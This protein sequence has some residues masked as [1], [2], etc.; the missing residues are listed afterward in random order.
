MNRIYTLLQ[1]LIQ[2]YKIN[3]MT[4]GLFQFN[5]SIINEIINFTTSLDDLFFLSGPKGSSKS[6]TIEKV[7]PE[8][9]KRNLIFRHFCFENSVI[10]DFLLNFY[11][12]LKE[13]S[14]S[15]KV[16]LKKFTTSDFKEKV[17]HYFKSIDANCIVIIENFEKIEK[18]S[19]IADFLSHLAKYMNVKLIIVSR[20]TNNIFHDIK[21]RTYKLE[22]ISEEDFKSK[23]TVLTQPLS[24]EIK[25][26]FYNIT[27]GLELYLNMSIKYC[28]NTGV[29]IAELM[30][31]FKRKS[32]NFESFIVSKFITLTPS[33]YRDFFQILSMLSHPVSPE[34]IENYK[35]GNISYID[36]LS[37]NFLISKFDT[38]VYVK[39]YFRDY[40]KDNIT[41]QEKC[42]YY[43]K[44]SAIYEEEL[45]KSPKDRLLRLSRESIRKEIE[46]FTTLTPLI[47]SK[48]Q[49]NISYIGISSFNVSD[50]KIK[51]KNVISEKLKRIKERK[52]QIS[53]DDIL[54]K[55]QNHTVVSSLNSDKEAT[56][57]Q[58]VNLIN[59][60]RELSR[61]YQYKMSNDKL[62]SA[63]DIDCENE[64]KIE[65]CLL[66]AKNYELLNE[67]QNAEKFY[68]EALETA[69][70]TYDIRLSEI[71]Y[72]L[73]SL[74][75][76]LYKINISQEQFKVIAADETAP[77]KYRAMASIELG[78]INEIQ[79]NFKGAVQHYENALSLSIGV[80]KELT[81]KAYFRLA[82][83]YDEHGDIENAIKYYKKNYT[84]S[85]EHNQNQYYS[86]SLT[87]LAS[88]Y[89]E[90][91][92]Q[93]E[94]SEFLK[95]A[96]LYDSEVNDL[97]NMY[98]SQKELGKLYAN[99]DEKS[100][101]AYYKQALD[102]ANKLN[103]TF[104]AALIY[105]EAGEHYYDKEEDEKALRNFFNAKNVLGNN[106]KDENM[107]RINSRIKDIKMRMDGVSYNIV[108]SK[109]EQQ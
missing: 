100:S 77:A 64:F 29:T 6:E 34:F 4:Q 10:N 89:T 90:Q 14:L 25:N 59:D 96:L 56:R 86:I 55:Q 5:T 102:S 72:N 45:T 62:L 80:N 101:I 97:E 69:S 60:A 105:F 71:Q 63:L 44:L 32:D 7:M 27:Q 24:E 33:N 22:Q 93:Q 99:I 73:A 39:D 78:E 43:K 9:K 79:N 53:K 84:T 15:G 85:S 28:A 19:E 11:D 67:N 92:K 36:Y 26:D 42:N 13:Y 104:K 87:N 17:S 30:N 75:K 48:Y 98:F 82:N 61:Q 16:S 57:M 47:N 51:Q 103:D 107:A 3:I 74:N 66:I 37:K 52:E 1:I 95:L 31:E 65:L 81:C 12:K 50:E 38:E 91:A 20:N 49:K 94:A 2:I 106:P 40:I 70:A 76:K 108:A 35:I 54:K 21:T 23:L 18:N 8:L 109:F 41:V 83:I 46:L 88:I 58:I 68:K